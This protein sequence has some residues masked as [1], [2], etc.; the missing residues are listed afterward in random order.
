MF[1]FLIVYLHPPAVGFLLHLPYTDL[2]S[3]ALTLRLNVNDLV[4]LPGSLGSS[5]QMFSVVARVQ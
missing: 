5:E 3:W 2:T 1:I 4:F